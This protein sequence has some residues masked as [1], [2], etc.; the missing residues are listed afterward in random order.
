MFQSFF[1]HN[2]KWLYWNPSSLKFEFDVRTK[3]WGLILQDRS[4]IL[5]PVSIIFSA[6]SRVKQSL[7]SCYSKSNISL[8]NSSLIYRCRGLP[9][10]Q[11]KFKDPAFKERTLMQLRRNTT[12]YGKPIFG[13]KQNIFSLLGRICIDRIFSNVCDWY[14][15]RCELYSISV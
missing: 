2:D 14:R 4:S 8:P 3:N 12:K 13:Q 6:L 15:L 5:F 7:V 11:T 1:R 9:K 10:F